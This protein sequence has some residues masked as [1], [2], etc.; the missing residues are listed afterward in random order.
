MKR[1]PNWL[2]YKIVENYIHFKGFP[3]AINAGEY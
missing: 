2:N 1:L 3:R